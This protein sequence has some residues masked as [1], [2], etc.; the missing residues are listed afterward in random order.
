M[1]HYERC[2]KVSLSHLF[3][4]R[5]LQRFLV[6]QALQ[7]SSVSCPLCGL[8]IFLRKKLQVRVRIR[9]TAADTVRAQPPMLVW[10]PNIKNSESLQTEGRHLVTKKLYNAKYIPR[11]VI[12]VLELCIGQFYAT[13]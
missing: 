4:L 8:F 2:I 6:F 3:L 12:A 1:S 13:T 7:I 5:K 10:N 11:F 9:A